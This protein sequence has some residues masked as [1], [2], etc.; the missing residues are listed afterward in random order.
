MWVHAFVI[1]IIS[2][3]KLADKGDSCMTGLSVRLFASRLLPAGRPRN[4]G[5][6]EYRPRDT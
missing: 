6:W 2:R 3:K 1:N 5:A 4:T